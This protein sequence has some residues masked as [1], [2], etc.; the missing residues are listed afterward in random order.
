MGKGSGK[1]SRGGGKG[2]RKRNGVLLPSGRQ[3]PVSPEYG[4]GKQKRRN[5]KYEPEK[6]KEAI[7]KFKKGEIRSKAE[8]ARSINIPISTFKNYFNDPSKITEARG[9]PTILSKEQE[10]GL[11]R[12]V[13]WLAEVGF[14]CTI[15]DIRKKART[16]AEN[17]GKSF[18]TKDGLASKEWYYGWEKRMNLVGLGISLRKGNPLSRLRAAASNKSNLEKYYMLI[19][20]VI[21]DNQIST[22]DI[23]NLDETFLSLLPN[24]KKIVCSKTA[25]YI[26]QLT[27]IYGEMSGH[28]TCVCY[29]RSNGSCSAPSFI[30]PGKNPTIEMVQGVADFNSDSVCMTTETGWITHDSFYLLLNDWVKNKLKRKEERGKVLL[31]MDGHSSHV[32]LKVAELCMVNNIEIILPPMHTSQINQPLD[33]TDFG[34]LKKTCGEFLTIEKEG[35]LLHEVPFKCKPAFDVAFSPEQIKLGFEKAGL[36]PL[37][38][39]SVLRDSLLQTAEATETLVGDDTSECNIFN[40]QKEVEIELKELQQ[41]NI[42]RK[43]KPLTEFELVKLELS[44]VKQHLFKLEAIADSNPELVF[45]PT[46]PVT[47]SDEVRNETA[48]GPASDDAL[49]QH[50]QQSCGH[51]KKVVKKKNGV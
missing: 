21:N 29:I 31:L 41:H 15:D 46:V 38:G 47:D 4:I 18:N 44:L 6:V 51:K 50:C 13:R 25:R 36:V 26:P 49:C 5:T 35:T 8:A 30:F 11:A 9:T 2:L 3:T 14:G 48:V 39:V 32:T 33:L 19:E 7:E 23:W 28:I 16:L 12:S 43:K 1:G 22:D 17:S 37:K 40:W 42:T 10:M 34:V 27:N 24:R 45:G 20:Q